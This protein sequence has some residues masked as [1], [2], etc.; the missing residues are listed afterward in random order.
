[1]ACGSGAESRLVHVLDQRFRR[2]IQRVIAGKMI[3]PG[4]G[5]LEEFFDGLALQRSFDLVDAGDGRSNAIQLALVLAANDFREKPL[6]HGRA[7][8]PTKVTSA[9]THG[10]K[11]LRKGR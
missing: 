5:E 1:M 11:T 10:I 8:N 7:F 3:P 4:G 9:M 2:S 6:D